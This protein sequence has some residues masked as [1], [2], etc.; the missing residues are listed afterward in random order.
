MDKDTGKYC[1]GCGDQE[2]FYGCADVAIRVSLQAQQ[3][4]TQQS[5]HMHTSI[6]TTTKYTQRPGVHTQ[7][8][9]VSQAPC[10]D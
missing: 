2:E 1:I 8:P 10:W 9:V 4:T 6:L 5:T 3:H 7:P